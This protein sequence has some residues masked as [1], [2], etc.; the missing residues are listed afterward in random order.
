MNSTQQLTQFIIS[1]T[2]CIFVKYGDGEFAAANYSQG[3]NCDGTS[4]SVQLGNSLRHSFEY[5]TNQPNALIGAWH[6]ASTLPFWENLT[7]K[8]VNWV[9]YHTILIDKIENFDKLLLF[10]SIKE[11]QRKKIYVANPLLRKATVLLNIDTHVKIAYSDWFYTSFEETFEA[12]K[13]EILEDSNTMILFSAGMGA[14]Y[15]ISRIH[16]EFPNVIYIDVGSGLDH[17]C[18]KKD[19]RGYSPP[20]DDLCSYLQPIL[21]ENWESDQYSSLYLDAR[22]NLGKNMPN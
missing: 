17:I 20:Y 16:M 8:K 11:T 1:N 5:I 10:K 15:L 7:Q 18:T 3:A 14:K 4:Y 22:T 19:T 21:P 6:S 12:V 2:P 9:N 13:K